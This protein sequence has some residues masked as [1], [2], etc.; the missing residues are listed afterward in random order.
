MAIRSFQAQ[1][2]R[3]R[4]RPEDLDAGVTLYRQEWE[5]RREHLGEDDYRIRITRANLGLAIRERARPGDLEEAL[6]ILEA[7]TSDR[8]GRYRGT[9]PFTWDVQ[10]VLAQTYVRAAEASQDAGRRRDHATKALELARLVAVQRHKRFG[11]T[12]A[13]TLRAQLVEAHALLLLGRQDEAVPEIRHV[14]TAAT[15][16]QVALDPGWAEFLLASG[17][18]AQDDAAALPIAERALALRESHYPGDSRQ[19][20]EARALVEILQEPATG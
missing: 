6:R 8:L 19:V 1:Y 16:R 20:A 17:L 5:L 9:H 12:D 4:G 15:V 14:R 3:R 7:E 11:W 2:I 18:A 13:A 10:T